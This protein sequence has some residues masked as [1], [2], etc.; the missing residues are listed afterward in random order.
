MEKS[1][2]LYSLHVSNYFT[3]IRIYMFF[4]YISTC[5]I[6]Q[7]KTLK[8]T[9]GRGFR[10]IQLLKLYILYIL[11]ILYSIIDMPSFVMF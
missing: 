5:F 7:K 3:N 9:L 2:P 6:Q 4:V 1:V 8:R 11:Y 10:N